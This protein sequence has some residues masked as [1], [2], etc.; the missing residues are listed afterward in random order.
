[1]KFRNYLDSI[2]GIGIFPVIGLIIFFV[3]FVFSTIWVMKTRK[4]V[5]EFESSLP[6]D[7]DDANNQ[8][9]SS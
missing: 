5:Y 3:V 2:A 9:T 6:L 4:Q 8:N 1:M 7:A